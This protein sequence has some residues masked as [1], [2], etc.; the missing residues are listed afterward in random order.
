[1]CVVCPAAGGAAVL[2]AGALA[3]VLARRIYEGGLDLGGPVAEGRGARMVLSGPLGALVE[4]DLRVMWRDPRLKA[5]LFTGLLGP[6]IPLFFV[7]RGMR[8]L[9]PTALFFIASF[10]GLG[11][12]GANAL[13]LERRGLLLLASFPLP[14]WQILVAKNLGAILLRLPG[15]LL[16]IAASLL[17]VPL[18][19]APAVATACLATML[20]CCGADNFI[21]ILFPV[22]MP[23]AGGVPHAGGGRGLG[24]A[25]LASLLMVGALAVSAPFV[26]L[27]WLPWLLGHPLLA[28]VTVPLA[29]AGA[30]AVYGMLVAGAARLFSAREPEFLEAALAEE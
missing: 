28:V 17:L 8:G 6:L 20:L 11:T 2:G 5:L 4:K 16:L 10:V 9:S 12:Y 7:W 22:P 1:A 15:L 30:V 25:A 23:P 29:L 21:A 26:F 14:R 24:A 19:L 3:V 18:L 27:A 13:A